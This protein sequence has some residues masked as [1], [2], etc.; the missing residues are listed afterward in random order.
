MSLENDVDFGTAGG[1]AKR[2]YL[3][4]RKRREEEIRAAHPRIGG[5]LVK[6]QDEPQSE[7]SWATGCEGE[8][9]LASGLAKRS[10]QALLLHDRRLPESRANID[11]LAIVASGVYVIDAKRYKG[12][13]EVR[14]AK[15]SDQPTLFIAG[16]RKSK[17]VDG[18]TRQV[19]AVEAALALIEQDVPVFGCFCFINP[20]KQAGGSKIPLFR[21]LTV[22]GFDLMYPRRLAKRLNQTGPLSSDEQ[23]VIAEALCELFPAA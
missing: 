16:R 23:L 5:L 18:L 22:E 8:E 19:K 17:L 6:L 12:K 1:S 21:T 3:R 4:R 11:H 20:E 15:S 14:K 13:I 10:P 9:Q 7:K 2:E